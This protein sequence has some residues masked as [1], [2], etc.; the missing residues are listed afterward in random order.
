MR[1]K[2]YASRLQPQWPQWYLRM[3]RLQSAPSSRI[4][5]GATHWLSPE[6][7]SSF[8]LSRMR[9]SSLQLDCVRR[10]K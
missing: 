10:E 1:V 5:R 8:K 3:T 7:S 4:G 6:S 9:S 2:R